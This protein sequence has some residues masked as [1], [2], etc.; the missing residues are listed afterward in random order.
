MKITLFTSNSPR[1]LALAERLSANADEIYMVQECNTV[2]PGQVSDFFRKSATMQDYFVRVIEAERDVFGLP[3]FLPG[4]VHQLAIKSGDLTRLPLT[5][6]ERALD[7]DLFIV[8]GASYIRGPL[9]DQLIDRRAINIHMGLSPYYRGSSC[10]FWAL[11]DN[12]PEY[13]GATVHL[14]SKGLDNGPMLYHVRPKHEAVDPFVLGMKAVEAAIESLVDRAATGDLH[15]MQTVRQD[16]NQQLRYTRNS[17][18]TDEVAKEY[19]DRALTP[20]Q[21]N[22]ALSAATIPELVSPYQPN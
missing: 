13:V 20:D 3:R 18:F 1:H 16:R 21:L 5:T 15:G 8:F 11:Y 4:N 14:L 10:N 12:R 9:A 17:D 6:L 19:L 7:S 2:F 22:L